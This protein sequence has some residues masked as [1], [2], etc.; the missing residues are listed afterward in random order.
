M[1]WKDVPAEEAA[2]NKYF[3]LGGWLLLFYVLAV[4]AFL[5]SFMSL[6]GVSQFQQLYGNK[7][8]ILLGLAIVQ[9][10]LQL[11]FIVLAPKKSPQMPKAVISAY[12]LGVSL[13]AIVAIIVGPGQMLPQLI[14]GVVYVALLQLYFKKS[15]RVNVTYLRRVPAEESAAA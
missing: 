9:A 3:G 1:E 14:I 5:G 10:I 6:F 8:A 15:R 7:Y 4:L 2:Q 13:S 12:W 11:P